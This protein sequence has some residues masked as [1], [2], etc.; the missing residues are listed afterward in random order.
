MVGNTVALCFPPTNVIPLQQIQQAQQ[1]SVLLVAI[2]GAMTPVAE[3]EVEL[4][5]VGLEV[6]LPGLANTRTLETSD[7][8]C[9]GLRCSASALADSFDH[10]M[11]TH[12]YDILGI[13]KHNYTVMLVFKYGSVQQVVCIPQPY[14]CILLS[15]FNRSYVHVRRHCTS[16]LI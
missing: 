12:T 9:M 14:F 15:Y 4:L 10:G 2:F 13:L 11:P 6:I 1:H 8:G 5:K 7:C 3:E 16:I